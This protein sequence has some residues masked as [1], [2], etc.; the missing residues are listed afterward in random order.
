MPETTSTSGDHKERVRAQ[1]GKSASDYV[2]SPTHSTGQD[3]TRLVELTE[4]TPEDRALDV[5]TGGGH[6]ALAVAPHA[7]QVVASDLTP[8]MLAAAEE[9]IRSK[10]VENVSFALADAEALPFDDA[11]FDIVTCRIA[12]HHF[13][14]VQAFVNE[15]AR[16]LRPG[17]RFVLM[18]SIGPEDN[19]LDA[20]INELEAR[21]DP[22]HVRSYRLSEWFA[23]IESAGLQIDHHEMVIRAH[24][25]EIWTARS[26]MTPEDRQALDEWILA[27]APAAIDY[28]GVEIEDGQIQRFIDHKVLLR[29]R[30]V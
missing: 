13:G 23:F 18:D 17:G 7:G 28:F 26:K 5:A 22:T 27:S 30:K 9:H 11:S 19:D 1:F 8:K 24:E 3:I 2:T 15:V 10:G 12:P 21:R 20:F 6:T 29:A 25:Y 16:V 14:D 4:A